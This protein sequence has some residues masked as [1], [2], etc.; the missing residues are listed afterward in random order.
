MPIIDA[1]AHL[2]SWPNIETSRHN[3]IGN[4]NRHGIDIAVLSHAD[5]SS[6]PGDAGAFATPLSSVEGFRQCI[7]FA[8]EHPC[9]FYLAVWV[10]PLLE[11]EPPQELLDLIA[12]NRDLVV[13][14]KLHPFC[15]RIS[16]NDERLEPYY[17]LA[18]SLD[19]PVLCHTALD[20]HSCIGSLI[21]AAKAHPDL[22]FVAA[23]LEL[24]SDHLYSIN[25]LKECP[26][27]FADTAWVD[28]ESAVHALRE[29]G[30]ERVLFG[31][32][33][34]LDGTETLANPLYLSYFQNW[35]GLDQHRYEALMYLNAKRFYRIGEK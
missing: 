27:I 33:N 24:G 18:R 6:Y 16:P 5:C 23:H 7:E 11:P 26:N 32:D 22:R 29:L 35:L 15:E 12:E 10:K 25:A 34:P 20:Y 31:T 1:H 3:L 28:M 30:E 17:D 19:V 21:E 4:M 13:A 14:L 9:R 8:H 2:G